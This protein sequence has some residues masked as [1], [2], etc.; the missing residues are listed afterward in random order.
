MATGLSL[1]IN[2]IGMKTINVTDNP[3]FNSSSPSDFWGRR[4]NQLIH[5]VLKR[6]V[7]KPCLKFSSRP[8]ATLFVFFASGLLHEYILYLV[9]IS[10]DAKLESKEYATDSLN[11]RP[12][13]G[14]HMIF[15]LWNGIILVLEN[16]ISSHL[17]IL[18][19]F[20]SFLPTPFISIGVVMISLP[21]AHFFIDELVE[22]G[23]YS[24]FK[25]SV[26]MI[27]ELNEDDVS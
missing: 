15:F 22:S 26:P 3:L 12:S 11:Y 10:I 25:F 27:I 7:F 5:G 1:A 2:L 8:I 14:N 23:C 4:W 17:V 20:K 9:A 16:I 24:D 18:K 13:Y 19:W 21:L 6:G